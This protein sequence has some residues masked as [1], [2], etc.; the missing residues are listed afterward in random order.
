MSAIFVIVV[1]GYFLLRLLYEGMQNKVSDAR[2]NLDLKFCHEFCTFDGACFNICNASN[3]TM[4]HLNN[5]LDSMHCLR[6]KRLSQAPEC[7]NNHSL[8][9]MLLFSEK[10]YLT[11]YSSELE[12]PHSVRLKNGD[13]LQLSDI[14]R[15]EIAEKLKTQLEKYGAHIDIELITSYTSYGNKISKIRY[16]VNPKYPVKRVEPER[17]S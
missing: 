14:D 1:G 2:I 7:I 6:G 15:M 12:I 11:D 17:L 13:L 4:Q 3:E 10:G 16:K 8:A 9:K 5:M